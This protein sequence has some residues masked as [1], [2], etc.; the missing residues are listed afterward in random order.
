MAH[1]F[2]EKQ[3]TFFQ[4]DET[5]IQVIG[6]GNDVYAV[7][8]TPDGYTVYRDPATRAYMF[9]VIDPETKMFRSSNLVV[10]RDDPSTAGLGKHLREDNTIVAD[11]RREKENARGQSE[12]RQRSARATTLGTFKSMAA[13]KK[14]ATNTPGYVIGTIIGLCIP[15]DFE[16]EPATISQAEIHEFCNGFGYTQFGNNGS[17]RDYFYDVSNGQLDYHNLV[18]PIYRAK[19][20]KS[21]YT[22]PMIGGNSRTIELI[23]EALEHF[24]AKGYDFKTLSVS[25]SG[26]VYALNVFYAGS[27]D[28]AYSEGLWPHQWFLDS[29]FDLGIGFVRDYQITNM[30]SQL[31]IG[32]FCHESGHLICGFPDLYDI[33][34]D[35]AGVGVFCLMGLGGT[36]DGTNPVEPCAFLKYRAGWFGPAFALDGGESYYLPQDENAMAFYSRS[37]SEYL[38]LEHRS[39]SGRDSALP[40]SGL[41]IWHIDVAMEGNNLQYGE[42][43]A[44]YLC[45]LLQADGQ[46]HLEWNSNCGDNRDLFGAPDLSEYPNEN[47]GMSSQWWD[48]TPT[49]LSLFDIRSGDEGT[50]FSVDSLTTELEQTDVDIHNLDGRD[51]RGHP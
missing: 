16:D 3:F 25:D 1:P 51:G 42:P 31:E 12:W 23:K 17:V 15:I 44:H 30:G 13:I 6:W 11:K 33:G 21:Y 18:T 5:E 49:G 34:L 24:L 37:D 32:T 8:E 41:A 14:E 36:W 38:I 10:G 48:N 22:D 27:N 19:H 46:F 2:F 43:D 28:N 9:A 20:Q 40:S 26:A 35:S 39:A 50:Q 47:M 29:P 4:P 45:A 7:F